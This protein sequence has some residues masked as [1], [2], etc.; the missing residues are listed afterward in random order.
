[1]GFFLP[2]FWFLYVVSVLA[3]SSWVLYYCFVAE[4]IPTEANY[5]IGTAAI[6]LLT[7]TLVYICALPPGGHLNMY[8]QMLDALTSWYT[9]LPLGISL[10][11][12]LLI[13][14]HI[15]FRMICMGA[16]CASF[17]W[18]ILLITG[19]SSMLIKLLGYPTR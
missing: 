10:L 8:W 15:I 13:K 3:P 11:F 1:M 16:S 14:R 19:F 17:L 5:W 4:K 9:Y 2:I 7:T 18:L 12:V 6:T